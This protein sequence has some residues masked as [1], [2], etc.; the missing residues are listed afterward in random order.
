MRKNRKQLNLNASF[1]LGGRKSIYQ[2]KEQ[3]DRAFDYALMEDYPNDEE[4]VLNTIYEDQYK[5]FQPINL[6][7][8]IK[9]KIA[10]LF[11]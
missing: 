8:Q 6:K 2:L 9:Q 5:L 4:T 3:Y 11:E 1:L 7:F 10:F